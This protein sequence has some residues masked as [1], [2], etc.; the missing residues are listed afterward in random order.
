M[1]LTEEIVQIWADL[2][3]VQGYAA[4][5][6]SC[7]G[8]I[9]HL[10][11]ENVQAALARIE[12]AEQRIDEIIDPDLKMTAV[13]LL[14]CFRT[15]LEVE[16]SRPYQALN[17]CA[18]GVRY[19]LLKKDQ[20]AAFV[21]EYLE[22]VRQVLELEVKRW[23]GLSFPIKLRK[24]C[25]DDAN[26]LLATL[27][28]LQQANTAVAVQHESLTKLIADYKSL[29]M[30]DDIETQ[31]FAAL[32][33]LLRGESSGPRQTVGYERLLKD[34]YDYPETARELRQRYRRWPKR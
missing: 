34:L 4:G 3:P 27:T 22:S 7:Q 2:F 1:S 10:L 17:T 24:L 32:F 31:D 26:Y 28:I 33:A 13:K 9:F 8:R 15:G 12:A 14:Q 20:Q 11:S 23:Q 21:G 29:F 16:A 19:I 6:S 5:L 18:D 30:S 25:I